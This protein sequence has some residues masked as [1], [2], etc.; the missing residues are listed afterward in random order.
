MYHEM[1]PAKTA[2]V[3]TFQN[4]TS[5]DVQFPHQNLSVYQK[6]FNH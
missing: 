6:L 2:L 3:M 1:I 5:F 4:K